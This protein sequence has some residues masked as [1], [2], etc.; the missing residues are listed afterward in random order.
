MN[1]MSTSRMAHDDTLA[2]DSQCS[3]VRRRADAGD[4]DITLAGTA[5]A[6][7][8]RACVA[9]TES[10]QACVS[11]RAED[12]P[13]FC[14]K[15]VGSRASAWAPLCGSLPPDRTQESW[16]YAIATVVASPA[17]SLAAAILAL[18]LHSNLALG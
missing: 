2:P 7:M 13:A 3:R 12:V 18:R 9:A 14:E 1:I 4:D 6:S 15:R 10:V 16:Y 17:L 5:Q 11:S 8:A